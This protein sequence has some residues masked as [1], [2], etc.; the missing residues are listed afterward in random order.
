MAETFA[1]LVKQQRGPLADGRF[2]FTQEACARQCG[3]SRS[4]WQRWEAGSRTPR[5]DEAMRFAEVF[6]IQ[7]EIVFTAIGRQQVETV[8]S[9]RGANDA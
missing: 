6:A 1:E 2:R 9:K 8:A 7:D 5:V 3:V 4:T